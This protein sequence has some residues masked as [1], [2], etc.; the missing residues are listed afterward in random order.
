MGREISRLDF[1]AETRR[2][3]QSRPVSSRFFQ[4][5]NCLEVGIF[6]IVNV[7]TCLD[8]HPLQ[9]QVLK[10][11]SIL[12]CISRSRLV[13]AKFCL[14]P[15]GW[16]CKFENYV[17]LAPKSFIELKWAKLGQLF[18]IFAPILPIIGL[19]C[20]CLDSF[21]GETR[22][23]ISLRILE[24]LRSRIVF[25]CII[26]F[27]FWVSKFVSSRLRCL[28]PSRLGKNPSRPIPILSLL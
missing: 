25:M 18:A 3:M 7:S 1:S 28:V 19:K 26:Y 13:L 10:H 5:R 9:A 12:S 8:V 22:R 4:S 11:F 14:D 16:D 6:E 2:E 20:H 24:Y 17:F 27:S 15:S 21:L 23:E